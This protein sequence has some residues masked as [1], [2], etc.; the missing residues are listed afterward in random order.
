MNP[1][2]VFVVHD[3]QQNLHNV[4]VHQIHLVLIGSAHGIIACKAE[5]IHNVI[6]IQYTTINC[7]AIT[8]LTS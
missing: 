6:M 2:V 8:M 7:F 4:S 1:T 5:F 3:T